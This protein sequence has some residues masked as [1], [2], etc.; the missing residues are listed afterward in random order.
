MEVTFKDNK[1]AER[2][3]N[4]IKH[5]SRPLFLT[6]KAGTGKSTLLRFLISS[7]DKKYVLL[8][9]TGIAALNIGGQ[10]IHSFFGFG[11]RP[12]LPLDR[13]LP[14][15]SGKIDLLRQLDLIIIDEISMVRA[16]IMNAIDLSLKKSLNNEL[17][18]GGKQILLVGDL[19]QL[20]PVIDSKKD[21]EV[22]IMRENYTTEFFFSAK[23]FDRFEIDVIE[24]QKVY[25]QEQADFVKILNNIR[26]NQTSDADLL[27]INSR[28]L[29][30][31]SPPH[32]ESII[33]LTTKNDKVGQINNEKINKIDKPAHSFQARKTGTFLSDVKGKKFP[34]DDILNLKEGAQIIF[35]KNDT[36]KKWVNGT[37]GKIHSI[38]E[39]E[40]EVEIKR[41]KFILEPVTWED[42][43]YKWNRAENKIDKEI[44]GT[45]TQYP[46]KLAWAITIHKSQ[47]Q[48][49]DKAIIDLDSGAFAGG[50]TYVA[51]SRCI[52]LEGILLSRKIAQS[53]IKVSPNAVKYLIAKGVDTLT[54]RD[55]LEIE[56]VETIHQLETKIVKNKEKIENEIKKTQKIEADKDEAKRK[57]EKMELEF[58][59]LQM[60]NEYMQKEIER[61]KSITWI[62]KLFGAK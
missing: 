61:L 36:E 20:P 46:I 25:R 7:I 18:F 57:I 24:L 17:P 32:E 45:F 8:A 43:E 53:D 3:I 30:G 60:V 59:R 4:I 56:L 13:D 58:Q 15:L 11:F 42:I 14:D 50:Q 44:V 35:V 38:E 27:R 34:T 26:I 39:G 62:Q 40:I 49:F 10:T 6:G 2:A 41:S 51:L 52:S 1:E 23:I 16:D 9:P 12:Y 5:T 37:I 47:G 48:T 29:N 22:I 55:N 31:Q 19:L 33:T 21:Q 28:Y 54:K